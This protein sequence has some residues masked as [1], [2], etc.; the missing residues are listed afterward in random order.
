MTDDTMIVLH[1]W[2]DAEQV[3]TRLG[4]HAFIAGTD[5]EEYADDLSNAWQT[6]RE[7][8]GTRTY[9]PFDYDREYVV[10]FSDAT[11][12]TDE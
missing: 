8:P 10:V 7:Q 12:G 3:Y 4:F 9:L 1:V 6:A 5:E 2:A 11:K